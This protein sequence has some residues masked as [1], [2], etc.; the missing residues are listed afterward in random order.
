MASKA[1]RKA[2]HP[3]I[4]TDST[5]GGGGILHLL[6]AGPGRLKG[7][8][9]RAAAPPLA[10]APARLG[11]WPLGR[12]SAS[13]QGRTRRPRP[14]PQPRRKYLSALGIPGRADCRYPRRYPHQAAPAV[15]AIAASRHAVTP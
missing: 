1:S 7:A 8:Q 14:D 5:K 13:E 9:G 6:S 12:R 15:G 10:R 11:A 3:Y 4:S 2:L